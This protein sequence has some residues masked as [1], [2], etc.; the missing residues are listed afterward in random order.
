MNKVSPFPHQVERSVLSYFED[1]ATPT[2]LKCYLLLKYGQ[3]DQLATQR[4]EPRHYLSSSPIKGFG[5]QAER[6]WRD[7]SAVSLLRKYQEL[8]TSFDRKAVAEGLFLSSEKQCFRANHRL[9]P[10][11]TPGVYSEEVEGVSRVFSAAR[12]EIS[13]IL[14]KCPD[15]IDGK[16]GPGSTFG[17]KGQ[18]TTVPDKMSSS[19]TMT[20]DAWPYLF[21][22]VGT[23]WASACASSGKS[24]VFVP[25]NRFTT[26]NKDCEK[27]RGIAIEPSLNVFYQLG[28]GR[29]I[30][31]RLRG[32]GIDLRNGQEIHKRVACEASIEGHLATMDLSNASDTICRNLVKLLLPAAWFEALD[33]LRSKKTLVRGSWHLLEKF[34]S[35][36]NGFTFELETLVFL[37]LILAV[38]SVTGHKLVIGENVFVYGDDIICPTEISK[39]V[40]SLLSFSGLSVNARKTFV[41]GPFRESCGGDYFEGVDVRPHYLEESPNE[42]QQLISLA[43]GLKRASRSAPGRSALV[44]RAWFSVLDSIPSHIR[45]LRGPSVLG[46][47]CLHDDEESRWQ[48]RWRSGIRYIRVYR[49][50]R[51]RKVSWQNFR[52]EV[53]LAAAL[54][55]TPS[56]Q[57]WKSREAP[58]SGQSEAFTPGGVIPRDGVL[59]YK[60]G[61][62]PRS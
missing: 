52:P 51:F 19:P 62:V 18:F 15:H 60:V 55:G 36:G 45:R 8:P 48:F 31:M 7:A 37:G 30:R 26:V 10:Y 50:A 58:I 39:D 54:L 61:W 53:T 42:P 13:R 41:D 59:G 11:L 40:I 1:L 29:V 38:G 47:L 28:L 12:K 57:N 27:D 44:R 34:S 2:S 4:L 32:A 23:L 16:H 3:W 49:P 6:Y 20:S 24:P 21:Q 14:G 5:G 9:F 17:D 46:D 56:G 33:S 43:N 35:M 22:W 25:G